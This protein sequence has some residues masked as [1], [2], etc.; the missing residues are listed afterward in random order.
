[1]LAL[2]VAS[3]QLVDRNRPA[4]LGSERTPE[5]SSGI[6]GFGTHGS[7]HL[8]RAVLRFVL[9]PRLERFAIVT[10]VSASFRA[11]GR[12][13]YKDAFTGRLV[14]TNNIRF[15]ARLLH[16]MERPECGTLRLESS[17]Y[18]SPFE[19]CM[20]MHVRFEAGFEY[21]KQPV[22]LL[23]GKRVRFGHLE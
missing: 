19:T 20:M 14:R 4:V 17:L 21:S 15:A 8:N 1:M 13:I 12:T 6:V 9:L 5:S 16:L 2:F 3:R 7:C 18:G 23:R 11:L 22:A 10:D